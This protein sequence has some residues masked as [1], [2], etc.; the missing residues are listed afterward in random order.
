MPSK[1]ML[2][3]LPEYN[4]AQ[5]NMNKEKAAEAVKRAGI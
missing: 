3:Y 2:D 1:E 5:D 4:E